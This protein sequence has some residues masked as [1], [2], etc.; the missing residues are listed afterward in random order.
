[1]SYNSEIA[2]MWRGERGAYKDR[3]DKRLDDAMAQLESLKKNLNG[4]VNFEVEELTPYHFRI[5]RPAKYGYLD[6]Y[7]VHRKYHDVVK[8]KR[9]SFRNLAQFVKSFFENLP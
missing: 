5:S 6:I 9:G 3:R 2:E 8:N 1:M 4:T 7:P